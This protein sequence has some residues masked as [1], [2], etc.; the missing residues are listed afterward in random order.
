MTRLFLRGVSTAGRVHAFIY[1][2]VLALRLLSERFCTP[3]PADA[4]PSWTVPPPIQA[5]HGGSLRPDCRG[6]S[7]TRLFWSPVVRC[8]N[9]APVG[10]AARR[11]RPQSTRRGQR[12]DP[13]CA[14]LPLALLPPRGRRTLYDAWCGPQL[15]GPRAARVLL[16]TALRWG[17][18]VYERPHALFA[19]DAHCGATSEVGGR[20]QG[21]YCDWQGPAAERR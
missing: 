18:C 21:P 2:A 9:P 5:L 8:C 15:G 3:S 16:L 10:E 7:D 17:G 19:S 4:S 14:L 20:G 13:L 12:R 1:F 6:S 11:G